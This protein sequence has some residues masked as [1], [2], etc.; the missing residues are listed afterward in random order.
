MDEKDFFE[1]LLKQVEKI[2]DRTG[3]IEKTQV[4]HMEILRDHTR[5]SL[6]NEE[7]IV[8]QRHYVNESIKVMTTALE[9]IQKHVTQV[10]TVLKISG[11]VGAAITGLVGL[12]LGIMELVKRI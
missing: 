4:A 9:P 11:L 1:L 10:E 8:L 3:E 2:A 7:A 5:R 6:A 12:I